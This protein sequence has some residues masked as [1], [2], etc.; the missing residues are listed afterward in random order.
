LWV[1]WKSRI[2]I[3]AFWEISNCLIYGK[4]VLHSA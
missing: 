2:F 3:A 1:I 4:M